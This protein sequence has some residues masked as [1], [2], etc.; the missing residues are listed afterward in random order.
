M[1]RKNRVREQWHLLKP[2]SIVIP[3]LSRDPLEV[4]RR[5]LTGFSFMP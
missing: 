1:L 5:E 4:E 3:A 2:G